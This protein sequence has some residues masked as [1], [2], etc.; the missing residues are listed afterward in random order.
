MGFNSL[1]RCTLYMTIYRRNF[2]ISVKRSR[3][4]YSTYVTVH[5]APKDILKQI[6]I[7]RDILSITVHVFQAPL[8][9]MQSN[10]YPFFQFN[11][12]HRSGNRDVNKGNFGI[13]I[14]LFQFQCRISF[15][16]PIEIKF[17]PIETPYSL[18]GL[19]SFTDMYVDQF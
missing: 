14:P 13:L 6:N 19:E 12:L 5:T 15:T 2:A 9:S 18:V 8:L 4:E 16:A 7:Q 3:R 17:I 11:D 10:S 1:R